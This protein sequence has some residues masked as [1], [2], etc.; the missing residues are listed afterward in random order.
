MH[1]FAYNS[2]S[3]HRIEIKVAHDHPHIKYPPLVPFPPPKS[4][5]FGPPLATDRQTNE[6]KYIVDLQ[7]LGENEF[8][9]A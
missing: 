1:I 7:V 9:P 8:V 6:E 3:I 4:P 5:W 2:K